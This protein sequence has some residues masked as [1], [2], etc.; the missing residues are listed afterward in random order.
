MDSQ[1]ALQSI[2]IGEQLRTDAAGL[3][4]RRERVIAGSPWPLARRF[5]HSDEAAWGPPEVLAHVAEM[6]PYWMGEVERVLEGAADG[7]EP[8]PFGRVAGDD[9]RIALIGRD[10]TVPVRELMSR[11]ESDAGRMARRIETFGDVE[12]ARRGLHP[13]RGEMSVEHMLQRFVIDHLGEH[14]EQLETLLA[15]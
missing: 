10:R 7:R 15:G 2:R 1:P 13:A 6:L 5:D 12:L 9:V 14:A 8:I 3:L 4:A 11:I